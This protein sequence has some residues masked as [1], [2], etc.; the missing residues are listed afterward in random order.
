MR[1]AR[2]VIRSVVEWAAVLAVALGATL[3]LTSAAAYTGGAR[4]IAPDLPLAEGMPTM[5]AVE[6]EQQ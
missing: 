4:L 3:L 6:G 5:F 1:T 2:A